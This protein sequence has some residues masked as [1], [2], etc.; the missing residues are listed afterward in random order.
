MDWKF[1]ITA[2]LNAI[3]LSFMYWQIRIMR[4]QVELPSSRS[5][6]RIALEKQFQRKLYTP[7]VV[8]ALL[9]LLSWLPFVIA[10]KPPAVVLQ[11]W[12]VEAPGTA[13]AIID[14]APLKSDAKKYRIAVI[15]RAANETIDPKIDTQIYR[16]S[17][18][19]ITGGNVEIQTPM[20]QNFMEVLAANRG[21]LTFL[22][23]E[24]PK[25]VQM[26]DVQSVHDLEAK[27]GRV[28]QSGTTSAVMERHP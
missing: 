9:V 26:Y 15:L 13:V 21:L 16:S 6:K 7:V 10:D 4:G 18:F 20:S 25:N 1:W 17:P 2:V 19:E 28:L 3:G 22:V 11:Y 12:G 8:M 27:G 23:V 24:V 5:A 14:T